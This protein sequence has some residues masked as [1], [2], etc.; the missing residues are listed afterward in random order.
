MYIYKTTDG[1]NTWVEQNLPI[2]KPLTATHK[3]EN[4][5]SDDGSGIRSIYF[6]DV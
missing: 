5:T 4:L 1:G 2:L 3:K 6:K